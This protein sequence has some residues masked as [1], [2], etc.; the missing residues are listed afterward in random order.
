MAPPQRMTSL[1]ARIVFNRPLLSN[2]STPTARPPS[3]T[4]RVTITPVNADKLPRFN[5]GRKYA[6]AVLHR[7]PVAEGAEGGE[8]EGRKEGRMIRL[9]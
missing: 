1:A 4:T 7:M 2:N 5:A 3:T 8:K 6:D 9:D